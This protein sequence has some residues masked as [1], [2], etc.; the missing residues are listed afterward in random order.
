MLFATASLVRRIEQAE[1]SLIAG[2]GR[3]AARH[4]LAGK[5]T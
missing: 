2:F 5:Y 1:A 4:A 3:A